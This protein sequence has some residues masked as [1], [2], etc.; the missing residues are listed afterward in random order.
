MSTLNKRAPGRRKKVYFNKGRQVDKTSLEEAKTILSNFFPLQKDMLIEYLHLF[1]DKYNGLYARHLRALSELMKISMSEVYEVA[2]FYAHF[3][4]VDGENITSPEVT[5]KVCESITCTMYGADKIYTDA[6][7]KYK[8]VR[9]EKA[10]CM[11]RC[12]YAPVVE[13]N[14]NHLL[15]ASEKSIEN[16][17]LNKD[18]SYH[19]EK[20]IDFDAYVSNGGYELYNKIINNVVTFE[21]MTDIF[22]VS[23]LRGLGGA[24]FPA[25]KKWQFV[26]SYKGPRLMCINADE[27]EPGNKVNVKTRRG[28][29]KLSVRQDRELPKGMI[30]I[31]FCFSEAAANKLTNPQLDPFGKIPEFKYCAAN[32]EAC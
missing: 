18:F 28:S 22:S 13:V 4:L 24:G 21:K 7:S 10:P 20:F 19:N 14:H 12:N 31:P 6:K 1:N 27:G 30:F 3:H 32:I 11:G 23:G 15:N 9:V 16:A 25:F 2:S 5:I 29:V 8:K 17:L 26:K